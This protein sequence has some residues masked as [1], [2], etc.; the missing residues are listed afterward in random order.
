[1]ELNNF[2]K[3]LHRYLVSQGF[4]KIKNKYYRNGNGFLCMIFFYKSNY[5]PRYYF[6]YYFFIGD[7]EEP[8]IINQESVATYT[9]YV[10]NRFYFSEK[11]TYSCEYANYTETQITEYL[12]Q[13]MKYSINPPFE[14]GKKY[15]L[16]NFGTIYTSVLDDAIIKPLL[17]D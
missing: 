13:N 6:D 12:N 15:L 3:C 8:Y 7:F 11:D 1:M 14:V 9:P 17:D 2:K 16:D 5:G 4:Q 10:G